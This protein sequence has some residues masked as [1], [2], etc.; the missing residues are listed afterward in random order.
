[1]EFTSTCPSLLMFTKGGREGALSPCPKVE[2]T[3]QMESKRK[4][5]QRAVHNGAVV[6][7][8]YILLAAATAQ[9]MGR[10]G[11]KTI[12]HNHGGRFGGKTILLKLHP[13]PCEQRETPFTASKEAAVMEASPGKKPD[14]PGHG[15]CQSSL[16]CKKP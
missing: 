2:S 12:L 13:P 14:T 3:V 15:G 7:L 9:S 16:F 10:F 1:M 6:L 8:V 11:G 4:T 5:E